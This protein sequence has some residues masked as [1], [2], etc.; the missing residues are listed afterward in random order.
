[1]RTQPQPAYHKQKSTAE[2][3]VW[4]QSI[5]TS[6][7]LSWTACQQNY[8]DMLYGERTRTEGHKALWIYRVRELP[9]RCKSRQAGREEQG[10]RQCKMGTAVR[11]QVCPASHLT[12]PLPP[13]LAGTCNTARLRE[14][15]FPAA[16]RAPAAHHLLLLLLL[17]PTSPHLDAAVSVVWLNGVT[18]TSTSITSFVPEK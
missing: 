5:H 18:E 16:P 6:L 11:P 15:T 17:A 4:A 13:S 8:W 14:Q 10:E 7:A 3:E 12:P 1:M 2:Q 9:T